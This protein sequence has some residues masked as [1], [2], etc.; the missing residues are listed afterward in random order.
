MVDE[1]HEHIYSSMVPGL[2]NILVDDDNKK[3]KDEIAEY[4]AL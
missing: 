4:K 2:I 3:L 1:T